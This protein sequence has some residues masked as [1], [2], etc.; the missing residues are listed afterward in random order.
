MKHIIFSFTL[1]TLF[2]FLNIQCTEAQSGKQWITF[3][4]KDGAG[5]G[6][7][8]VLVSGD[9]EYR[10]EEALPMLAQILSKHHGFKCTVLFA[11]DPKT[12]EI[13]PEN[14]SNIPGLEQLQTADLMV[15]FTRFRELPDAQM[16][17]IDEYV[18]SGKPVVALRTATHAF[19]YKNNKNSPYAKYSYDSKVKDWEDGYGRQ[20]LGE[21]WVSHHGHHAKEGTRGL[22]NGVWEDHPV[23]QSVKDI[24]GPTDVYTI[25]DLTPDATVLVFGQS[26]HGMTPEAPMSYDKSIMPVAWIKSYFTESGKT[27]R[28]F[29]TTMGAAVDLQSEDLR[30]LVVNACYWG[31]GMEE[32]IPEKSNV[33]ITGTYNPTMFGFGDQKKGMKPTD[34][35]V[36][37]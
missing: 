23:L 37:Q 17:Y 26:T 21:T 27:A 2:L 1:A 15:L 7:H 16:K 19:F 11:I 12:G 10:S 32:D 25:R 28:I 13:D 4:G 18:Q 36:K 8:I 20:A 22:I 31:L 6:K 5:K 35:E 9:E 14:I 34:F 3:E 33:E 29:T 30:R 24:W